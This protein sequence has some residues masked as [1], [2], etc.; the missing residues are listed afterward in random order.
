MNGANISCIATRQLH[1]DRDAR[2]E[3]R[4]NFRGFDQTGHSGDG[5]DAGYRQPFDG[6]LIRD[7]KCAAA[8]V[9]GR[10]ARGV[11]PGHR[12]HRRLV[13]RGCDRHKVPFRRPVRYQQAGEAPGG[14]GL[15]SGRV[16]AVDLPM[17]GEPGPDRAGKSYGSGGQG[18]PGHPAGRHRGRREPARNS[19]GKLR[20][21]QVARHRGRIRW[22]A[23]RGRRNDP[24]GGRYPFGVLDRRH[25]CRALHGLPGLLREGACGTPFDETRKLP[26]CRRFPAQPGCLGRDR[27][28][29]DHH[30]CPFQRSVRA[31]EGAGGRLHARLGAAVAGHHA[32]RLWSDGLSRRQTVGP[33]RDVRFAA[34]KP[35][36]SDRCPPDAR[37]CRDGLG[38]CPRHGALGIAHGTLAGAAWR[39]DCCS[40]ARTSEGQRLWHVQ[41][42]DRCGRAGR[43]YPGRMAVAQCGFRDAFSRRGR[44]VDP[45]TD[46]HCIGRRPIQ[47][48]LTVC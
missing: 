42:R 26:S 24:A 25:S 9:S 30:A 7:D 21:A 39:D 19:R 14:A 8:P 48:A 31:A 37:L 29:F 11:G 16:V 28:G 12:V 46:R 34:W 15:W 6:R 18:Y 32:R 44:N 45:R 36:F 5:L 38:L 22:P 10:R 43:E 41:S 35:G 27:A 23:G 20:P 1:R 40:D 33:D 17:G 3:P 4:A 2:I 13:G 47:D